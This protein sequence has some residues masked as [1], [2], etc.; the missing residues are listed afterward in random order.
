ML[1]PGEGEAG[2]SQ[3]RGEGK[4]DMA[5]MGPGRIFLFALQLALEHIKTLLRD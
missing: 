4:G 5:V 3:D 1:P 2:L